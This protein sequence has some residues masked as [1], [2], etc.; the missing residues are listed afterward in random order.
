MNP[1]GHDVFTS[2]IQNHIKLIIDLNFTPQLEIRLKVFKKYHTTS[3]N[4]SM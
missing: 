1:M 4:F 2:V 3:I